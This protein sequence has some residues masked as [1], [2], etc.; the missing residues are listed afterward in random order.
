MAELQSPWEG[1]TPAW[2]WVSS[3]MDTYQSQ[4]WLEAGG[5]GRLPAQ[6]ELCPAARGLAALGATERLFH[7]WGAWQAGVIY[8]SWV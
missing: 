4:V 1:E 6:A 8:S 5:A 7:A 2:R 3:Q